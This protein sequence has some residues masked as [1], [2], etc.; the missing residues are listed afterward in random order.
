[1]GEPPIS[2]DG[3]NKKIVCL[4]FNG[5]IYPIILPSKTNGDNIKASMSRLIQACL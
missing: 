5:F 4:D 2:A 3:K 1:L